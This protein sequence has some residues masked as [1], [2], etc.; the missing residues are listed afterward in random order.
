MNAI[1]NTVTILF[2]L[3][4]VLLAYT[5]YTAIMSTANR[6]AVMLSK[7][8]FSHSDKL[9]NEYRLF[10]LLRIVFGIILLLRA[11]FA[12]EYTAPY[13]FLELTGFLVLLDLALAFCLLVGFLTQYSILLLVFVSWQTSEKILGSGTLG[14][15]VAAILAIALAFLS[16][17]RSLSL[18]GF[19][20]RKFSINPIWLG[21][22]YRQLDSNS[23]Y[24]VKFIALFSYWC[25]CCYSLSMHLGEPAWTTGY[26]GP[27]L[28]ANNFMSTYWKEFVFLFENSQIMTWLARMSL[29]IMILWY[30]AIIPFVLMGGIFRLF[31]IFWG[32]AFF[33]LSS[34]FLNLGMLA[35]IE[36]VFWALLFLPRK[37]LGSSARSFWVFY[38]DKCNLCYNTVRFLKF[39]DFFK[40]LS[41]K[42][43]SI[44]GEYLKI[45][46]V[47]YED[48][49]EDLHGYDEKTERI[50]AGYSF[51]FEITKRV[52]LLWI[53]VP[54]LFVGFIGKIGPFIYR[55]I[56][57]RR[58]AMFGVCKIIPQAEEQRSAP[59]LVEPVGRFRLGL[60][61]LILTSGIVYLFA[62]PAPYLGWPGFKLTVAKQAHNF[63]IA[64]INVFNRKDLAMSE[65]WF[66]LQFID[67]K[68]RK[69]LVPLLDKEG[70]RL[71]W[72]RS[73]RL[74]F[75]TTLRYR[76]FFID[77][78][79]CFVEGQLPLWFEKNLS[80]YAGL[81]LSRQRA[82]PG[83]YEFVYKQY[84][85]KLAKAEDIAK[86]NVYKRSKT[87]VR[88]TKTLTFDYVGLGLASRDKQADGSV[89]EK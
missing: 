25:V 20:I 12:F 73:D 11:I 69:K 44:S 68:G 2:V 50:F 7:R 14:N 67:H 86:R 10:S 38:D 13:E 26:A 16:A 40:A 82:A 46:G 15:D 4:A 21:Y 64:P 55:Q 18:D 54:L 56:A 61:A 41:F 23:I 6:F 1:L 66:T 51:Y 24:L 5:N 71:R 31:I 49:M 57:K 27:Q 48:A 62:M 77:K 9:E 39:V 33:I 74:Y 89:L 37:W 29:W 17:G 32:I 58:R 88:C 53:F 65:N 60:M 78:P 84:H 63:G 87:R 43:A 75:G 70:Q 45:A 19:L 34:A 30:V 52:F 59:F 8:S 72:H 42:P 81:Y 3:L 47:S 76:R 28:L 22:S 80:R 83:T 85:E 36:F 35:E 79:G